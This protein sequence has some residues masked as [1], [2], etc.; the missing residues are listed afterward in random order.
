MTLRLLPFIAVLCIASMG[1]ASAQSQTSS[2]SAWKSGLEFWQQFL[3]RYVD[4]TSADRINRVLYAAITETDKAGLEAFVAAQ[5]EVMVPSL[6]RMSQKA[7]WINLYNAQVIAIAVRHY[8]FKSI[9]DL[10]LEGDSTHNIF[11][12]RNLRSGDQELSLDDI[13]H[14]ILH[15]GFHDP[16]IHFAL[17]C[18]S[19]GCPNLA[20]VPFTADNIDPLMAKSSRDF[21]GTP[22]GAVFEDSTLLL[23]RIFE[24]YRKDF[25][26]KD[27]VVLA[28]LAHY[29][30]PA[31]RQRLQN[32]RGKLTYQY[33]WSLNDA[34]PDPAINPPRDPD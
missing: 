7:F 5:Q 20:N 34:L 10:R 12:I 6:S 24:W 14:R 30:D 29:A 33:D 28:T 32:Y 16:R 26:N 19:I 15:D 22:R 27:V 23:S 9:L 25:G 17:N 8:P 13:E 4:T 31:L 2:D 11:Q 21:L 3:L 1:T 18:A